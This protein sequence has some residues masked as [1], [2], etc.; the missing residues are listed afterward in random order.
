VLARLLCAA[1]DCFPKLVRDDLET[2]AQTDL[3]RRVGPNPEACF[4]RRRLPAAKQTKVWL[5][6]EGGKLVET[7][8]AL[9]RAAHVTREAREAA[10]EI[11]PYQ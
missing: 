10:G 4:E 7:L 2:D 5:N 11:R 8:R 1:R 6:P 9:E 3:V